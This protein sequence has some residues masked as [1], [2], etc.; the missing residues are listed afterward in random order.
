MIKIIINVMKIKQV[1]QYTLKQS[2]FFSSTASTIGV[3]GSGATVVL[4]AYMMEC[5]GLGCGVIFL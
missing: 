1:K 2:Y 3:V 5:C 4:T